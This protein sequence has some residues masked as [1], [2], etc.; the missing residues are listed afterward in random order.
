M[1]DLTIPIPEGV[2][3]AAARKVAE[4]AIERLLES[5]THGDRPSVVSA[6]ERGRWGYQALVRKYG[7]ARVNQWRRRGG[8]KPNP[9]LAQI[10][11]GQ[12]PE[13]AKR[14]VTTVP[15]RT[16][17]SNRGGAPIGS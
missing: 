13:R 17:A 10:Q 6:A 11:S 2:D 5:R 3:A 16:D 1:P 12:L 15:A 4:A 7:E 9:T 8:R 14:R